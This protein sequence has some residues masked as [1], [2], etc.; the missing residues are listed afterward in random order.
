[1]VIWALFSCD[2]R[3]TVELY[4][5]RDRA[6][7]DMR[8]ASEDE[9]GWTDRLDLIELDLDALFAAAPTPALN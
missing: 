1:M 2:C 6:V 9:P 8:A 7:A 4:V 3:E 5:D